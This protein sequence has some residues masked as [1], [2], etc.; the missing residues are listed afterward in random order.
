MGDFVSKLQLYFSYPADGG[1][2]A[3]PN[4]FAKRLDPNRCRIIVNSKVVSVRK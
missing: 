1:I 2:E 3:V 4:G